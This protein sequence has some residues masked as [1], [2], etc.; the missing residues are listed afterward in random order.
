MLIAE[1]YRTARVERQRSSFRGK[2]RM[3]QN[4]LKTKETVCTNN[5][6][7]WLDVA[8]LLAISAITSFFLFSATRDQLL[9]KVHLI[10]LTRRSSFEIFGSA[11]DDEEQCPFPREHP[12]YDT[13]TG[14]VDDWDVSAGKHRRAKLQRSNL[15]TQDDSS[16]LGNSGG[17]AVF[18]NNP[19]V[20]SSISRLRNLI[21]RDF[22]N[23]WYLSSVS[24]DKS[25]PNE[26]SNVLDYAFESLAFRILQV[27]WLNFLMAE[28]LVFFTNLLRYVRMTEEDLIKS[29]VFYETMPV[30]KQTQLLL[31]TFQAN[32]TLHPGLAD[33]RSS[34]RKISAKL[35]KILLRENDQKCETVKLLVR[36]VFAC[37]VNF[38]QL[39][40]GSR[41][42]FSF[43][44]CI[45]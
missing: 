6:W 20:Y 35:T 34:L 25:F 44:F 28:A 27:D 5:S 12:A 32:C 19:V 40:L 14:S 43:R 11:S 39:P 2:E 16:G 29:N 30:E 26:I 36:E 15:A 13:A 3:C 42:S 41:H 1:A 38:P 18:K 4:K 45:R 17:A 8:V 37:N 21:V 7:M 33:P 24:E 23:Y 10:K 22:V 9:R 31:E